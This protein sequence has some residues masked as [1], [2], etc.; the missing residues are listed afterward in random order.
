MFT[1]SL[2]GESGESGLV[3]MV[4]S[5]DTIELAKTKASL[6]ECGINSSSKQSCPSHVI[7]SNADFISV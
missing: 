7:S 4:S 2:R 6:S 5:K 1:I 3:R